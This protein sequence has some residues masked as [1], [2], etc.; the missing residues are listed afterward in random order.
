MT[1]ME[2]LNNSLLSGLF[3]HLKLKKLG[4]IILIKL[5]IGL[6]LTICPK[7]LKSKTSCFRNETGMSDIVPATN[8][9]LQEDMRNRLVI[10][11]YSFQYSGGYEGRI[12]GLTVRHCP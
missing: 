6:Y 2:T 4:Q 11:T 3:S 9:F 7:K 8:P 10:Y 1:E 5:L 12:I